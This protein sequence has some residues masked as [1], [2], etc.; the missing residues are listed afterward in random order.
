MNAENAG[1][2]YKLFTRSGRGRL[3]FL[4]KLRTLTC[5]ARCWRSFISLWWPVCFSLL[6]FVGGA[7]SEPATNR[8]NKLIRKAGSVI[9]CKQDTLEAVVERKTLKKT[10]IHHG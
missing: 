8:L 9:G 3:Y 2:V 7:G 5:A 6:W 1:V 4:G 10:V